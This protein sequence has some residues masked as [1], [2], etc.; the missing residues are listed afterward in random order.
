MQN[1]H[2]DRTPRRAFTLIELLVVIAIIAILASILFP[3]F[4]RAR[5]NARRSSCLS[6]LKQV[7]L[8]V[9]QY[10]Q[11]YDEKLP[12][13]PNSNIANM[14]VIPTNW[15]YATQPY[16]KSW[17]VFIC[18]SA[19]DSGEYP[20]SGN[21]KTSY[22]GNGVVFQRP[23][24][25]SLAAIDMVATTIGV[26]EFW[27][28]VH[29]A[30]LRPCYGCVSTVDPNIYQ[31]WMTSKAYSQVHFDG[32]NLLFLDGHAKWRKTSSICID[33]FGLKN[34]SGQECGDTGG[35]LPTANPKF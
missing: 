7:G 30:F 12:A 20:P 1:F 9:M 19:T 5:E 26:Q 13:Q 31:A 18:P 16:I 21:S 24:G 28:N 3:V 34:S 33:E 11:D 10:T 23:S 35:T 8:G 27:Q 22:I 25:L 2:S 6:N 4:A 29:Y 15:I 17:Q 32:G 14:S